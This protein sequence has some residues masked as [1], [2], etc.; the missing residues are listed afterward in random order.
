L[1]IAKTS[2]RLAA[3]DYADFIDL[4]IT[5]WQST[6][7]VELWNRPNNLNDWGLATRSMANL[8]LK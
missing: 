2:A 4:M 3:K 7:V 8:Q 5:R 6:S 1:G